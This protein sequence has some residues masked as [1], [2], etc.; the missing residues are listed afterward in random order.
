MNKAVSFDADGRLTDVGLAM[1]TYGPHQFHSFAELVRLRE[2]TPEHTLAWQFP[3][4]AASFNQLPA[5][6][7]DRVCH[8]LDIHDLVAVT[9]TC[10]DWHHQTMQLPSVNLLL[11]VQR[12]IHEDTLRRQ[13]EHVEQQMVRGCCC[14]WPQHFTCLY[15]FSTGLA[16]IKGFA[17]ENS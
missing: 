8:F 4:S 3:E 10:R 15:Y 5:L 12:A 2:M 13:W 16:S 7:L 11:A 1:G 9:R 14:K 6:V 17:S